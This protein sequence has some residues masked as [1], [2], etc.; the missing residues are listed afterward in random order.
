MSQWTGPALI[1]IMALRLIGAK[2]HLTQCWVIDDKTLRSTLQYNFN[3][4]IKLFF[5]ENASEKILCEMAVIFPRRGG[6]MIMMSK[7]RVRM[8]MAIRMFIQIDTDSHCTIKTAIWDNIYVRR[9]LWYWSWFMAQYKWRV[10][11][12]IVFTQSRIRTELS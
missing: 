9:G 5:H 7:L 6:L 8:R 1:K 2:H 4:N 12:A 11:F 10:P 3:Q